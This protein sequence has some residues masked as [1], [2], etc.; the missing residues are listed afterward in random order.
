MIKAV[1]F[2]FD[3]TVIDNRELDYQGFVIPSKQLKVPILPKK[4]IV[5]LRR[6]RL[7]AKDIITYIQKQTKAQFSVKEFLLLRAKFLQSANS[8]RFIYLRKKT[9]DLL[10][11]LQNKNIKPFL[12]TVRKDKKVIL[13]FLKLHNLEDV[14][15]KIYTMKDI[16]CE[17]ENTNSQNRI[18]I[19]NSL[20]N[21]II[22][23]NDFSPN[24][25]VFVGNSEDDFE[26]GK[27]MN[28]NFI[29]F[30]NSY[31]KEPFIK[32]TIKISNMKTLQKKI[33]ILDRCKT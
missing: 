11:H 25:I 32:N 12:C 30:T 20:I 21:K 27:Q 1:I 3:D 31:I 29:L 10:N 33:D 28:V 2:D 24:E 14:F 6:N 17:L 26:A 4:E 13:D 19:K 9:E 8:I 5:T 16:G 7:L 22:K 23:N 18:L 15:E